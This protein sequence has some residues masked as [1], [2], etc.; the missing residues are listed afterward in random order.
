MKQE[1]VHLRSPCAPQMDT[2]S[3]SSRVHGS[4]PVLPLGFSPHA[5]SSPLDCQLSLWGPSR[6]S[7]SR[8]VRSTSLL[9]RSEQREDRRNLAL[10]KSVGWR[11][12]SEKR[13]VRTIGDKLRQLRQNWDSLL[14]FNHSCTHVYGK[15]ALYW[16]RDAENKVFNL[17]HAKYPILDIK[18][19]LHC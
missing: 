12:D 9:V 3:A 11:V 14:L 17:P 8:G 6:M 10:I 16:A 5:P 15:P 18:K 1:S 4:V 2:P 13:K 19:S 7:S